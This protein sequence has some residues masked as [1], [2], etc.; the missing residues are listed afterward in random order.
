MH[1]EP[2]RLLR[3]SRTVNL[4]QGTQELWR[5]AI[6]LRHRLKMTTGLSRLAGFVQT[7]QPTMGGLKRMLV[8]LRRLG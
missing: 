7:R 6:P 5:F 8:Y 1:L 3:Q 2:R 4:N